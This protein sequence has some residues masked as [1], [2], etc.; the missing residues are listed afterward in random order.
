MKLRIKGNSLRL[1]I[2]PSELTR[3]LESGR[4]DETIHFSVDAS[5]NLTYALELSGVG[6]AI[7]VRWALQ[8]VVVVIPS[9]EAR[10]WGNSQEVGLYSAVDTAAGVLELAVEKDFACLDKSDAENADTFPNPLQ[11]TVC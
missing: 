4:I 8:Q 3:L 1:R 6:P 7:D 9:D 11:G 5:A 2:T 10:R